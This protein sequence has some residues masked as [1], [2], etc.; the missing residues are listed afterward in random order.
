MEQV[1]QARLFIHGLELIIKSQHHP[2]VVPA[3]LED[4]LEEL[5][6]EYL[7]VRSILSG[8]CKPTDIDFDSYT[9]CIG[10]LLSNPTKTFI[11]SFHLK[12]VNGWT[13]MMTYPFEIH[14]QVCSQIFKV[15]FIISL[16]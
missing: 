16:I 10:L 4:C 7:D 13:L 11:I 14:G 9:L 5:D 1:F 8:F 2:D 3:A 15:Y 6:L 12:M